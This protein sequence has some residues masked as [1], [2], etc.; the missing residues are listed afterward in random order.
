MQ[1]CWTSDKWVSLPAWDFSNHSSK[2]AY[3]SMELQRRHA[4]NNF[5][6]PD[7]RSRNL[8]MCVL[9]VGHQ[10]RYR[11]PNRYCDIFKY[12]YQNWRRY[13]KYWKIPTKI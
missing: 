7:L 11:I 10:Y 9:V 12:R 5:W 3:I 6:G 1:W 2:N 13:Y 8:V 4:R